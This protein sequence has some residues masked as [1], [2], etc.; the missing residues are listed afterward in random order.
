MVA[1]GNPLGLRTLKDLARSRAR[2]VN[3]QRGAGTRILL[4]LKLKEAGIGQEDVS[5]YDHE[6]FTHLAVA[7][8][9]QSGSADAGLGIRGAAKALGIDFVPLYWEDYQ[10]VMPRPLLDDPLLA[11]LLAI[12]RDPAFAARVEALG[13]YDAQGMGNLVAEQEGV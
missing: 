2:Y 3:R 11:P 5:G 9:V 7:A 8:A 6:E 13:G 10:L 1:P 4:D 12:L